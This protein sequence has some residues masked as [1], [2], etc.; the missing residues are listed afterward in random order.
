MFCI[1]ERNYGAQSLC[2]R[3]N[4]S[5]PRCQ[6]GGALLVRPRLASAGGVLMVCW[7]AGMPMRLCPDRTYGA[8][9]QRWR[10]YL[11]VQRR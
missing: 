7:R 5:M 6:Q 11:G 2:R 1:P 9:H 8:Q 10:G 4:L 3:G